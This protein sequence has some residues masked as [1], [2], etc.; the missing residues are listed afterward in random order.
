MVSKNGDIIK[1][2]IDLMENEFKIKTA[3]F[4]YHC[5]MNIDHLGD[6]KDMYPVITYHTNGD[7]CTFLWLNYYIEIINIQI[8]TFIPKQTK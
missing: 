7:K 2:I 1:V 6:K 3:F 4:T 5:P 8:N